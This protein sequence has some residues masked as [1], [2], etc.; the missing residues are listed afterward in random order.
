MSSSYL[1]LY[2]TLLTPIISLY[3]NIFLLFLFC[4]SDFQ[5]KMPFFRAASQ[6]FA[7]YTFIFAIFS[8]PLLQAHSLAPA[9][10]PSSDGNSL[11]QTFS[12]SPCQT[13]TNVLLH[14]ILKFLHV[15]EKLLCFISAPLGLI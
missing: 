8:P 7:I 5:T 3:I 11:I 4:Y 12:P 10:A 9:P 2:S 14:S 13:I 15:S 6:V 1:P